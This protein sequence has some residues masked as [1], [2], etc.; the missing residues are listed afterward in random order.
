MKIETT[1]K[2]A[3]DIEAS[4]IAVFLWKDEPL[5]GSALEIDTATEGMLTRLIDAGEMSSD[6][7]AVT[8]LLSPVGV[9]AKVLLVVGLGLKTDRAPGLAGRAVGTA[10]KSLAAKKRDTVGFYLDSLEVADAVAGVIV[11]VVGQGIY[12]NKRK[13]KPFA[14]ACF[15]TDDLAAVE[16][17][18]IMGESKNLVRKLVNMP[19]SDLYPES[20][21]SQAVEVGKASGFEV[22]VWDEKR[23][24]QE[25]C[26][27]FLAVGRA[28]THPPRLVIMKYMGGH[29]D[30][31]AGL[32]RQR[33]HV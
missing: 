30:E 21:A 8:T 6:A 25:R 32:G 28:S 3:A 33:R 5:T 26:G 16:R 14:K 7:L 13:L 24:E 17:G 18:K 29:S 11:G 22:E 27:A 4:A 9:T 12:Q 20:F 2:P 31:T 19:A 23:L 10:A 15:Q 1:Q